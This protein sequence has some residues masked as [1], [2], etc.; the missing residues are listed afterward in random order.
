MPGIFELFHLSLLEVRQIGLFEQG[1]RPS[2]ED[3]L[4]GALA[5]G[6]TF[7][8]RS[9]ECH[10][11]PAE[12]ID[13][14]IAGNVLRSHPRRHHVPPEEGGHEVV[15]DEWQGSLVLID[16]THHDDGQKVSFE[17]DD[18]LGK[19]DAVLQS[20]AA[21]I[22]ALPN[23]PYVIEPKP[24]FSESSFWSWAA[25]HEYR[26]HSVSFEF[27]TPN[28]FGSKTAFDEEMKEFGEAGVATVKMKLDEGG[29][30]GGIDARSEQIRRAVDYSAQGG[31]SMTAKAKNGD[32]F[33][34]TGETKTARLPATP[35]E[36]NGGLKAIA[37][38]FPRLFGREQDDS[39]GVDTGGPNDPPVS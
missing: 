32:K 17:R 7:Q 21:Y 30:G 29:R 3:W 33:S 4:R 6:F 39:L 1:P 2:R 14:V 15:S 20:M 12:P 11:V 38:W 34:S 36:R 13:Q 22:N 27:V 31:G 35:E 18:T 26:L 19:P 24:I 10:W 16:P 23:A 5:D 8:H 9:T 25:A 28:M 37:K